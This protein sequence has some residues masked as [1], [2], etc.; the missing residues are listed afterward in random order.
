MTG[1]D[2][3]SALHD[4][5]EDARVPDLLDRALATS[6]RIRRRRVAAG[7]AGTAA[8]LVMAA[9]AVATVRPSSG[10]VAPPATGSTTTP[11]STSA[12]VFPAPTPSAATPPVTP[13]VSGQP[14]AT[15]SAAGGTVYY[16][17][18][19]GP[20]HSVYSVTG[21]GK[22]KLV[23]ADAS[24]DMALA[25]DA[26][27]LAWI[28]GPTDGGS[29]AT[30]MVSN[31]DGTRKRA[32]AEAQYSGGLCNTPAWS[33]DSRRI[34]FQPSGGYEV[35]WVTLDVTNGHRTTLESVGACYPTWSPDGGTIGWY[36][37]AS[38]G[39]GAILTDALGRD[40]RAIPPIDGVR[41]P[42][43][44]GIH[45][46]GPGG[47]RAFVDKPNPDNAACGD[48]PGRSAGRGAVVDTSTG[49]SLD[50]PVKGGLTSAVFLADGG[51]IGR[52]AL[53]GELVRLDADLNLMTR[54]PSPPGGDITLLAYV[55]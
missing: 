17:Q 36:D 50:L 22:P 10:T 20:R 28:E 11:A 25:P 27:K 16:L 38:P 15:P 43:R 12:P 4:L 47:R 42:C 33:A 48:G 34:M 5:G 2:L 41:G 49:R 39:S 24:P 23:A 6:R 44:I 31:L 29:T 37:K 18:L 45:A 14:P 9:I 53:T 40:E 30:V 32:V 52:T 26:S 13:S 51:L 21:A 8:V 19:D 3:R 7:A 46:V 55:P 54:W 35:P 1:P